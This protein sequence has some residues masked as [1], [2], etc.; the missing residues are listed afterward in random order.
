MTFLEFLGELIPTEMSHLFRPS[1]TN[2]SRYCYS[3]PAQIPIALSGSSPRDEIKNLL[4]LNQ[5]APVW[6]Y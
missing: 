3:A 4:V 2:P 5:L 6:P 1:A